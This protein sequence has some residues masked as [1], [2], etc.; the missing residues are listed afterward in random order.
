METYPYFP[1]FVDLS[2]K[3]VL[4]VGAGRIASRRI[5]SLVPF[6]PHLKVV[7]ARVRPE[8]EELALQKRIVLFKRFFR[9]EDLEGADLVL[10]ATSDASLNS[11]IGMECKSRGIF[12]NVCSDKDMC[13]FY[14]PGIVM[15]AKAVVGVT[16]SG[17]DHKEAKEI[18]GQIRKRLCAAEKETDDDETVKTIL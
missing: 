2:E 6:A 8:V 18:T 12:V 15:T 17:Q 10:A 14:F 5:Q 11:R 4:V 9:E 16:A 13:D 3:R 1:L 7:A